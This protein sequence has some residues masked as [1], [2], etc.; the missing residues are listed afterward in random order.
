MDHKEQHHQHHEHERHEKKE[1]HKRHEHAMEQQPRT[2]H[3]I[4]FVVIGLI[5]MAGV[6]A[7]WMW[8]V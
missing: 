4:W 2:I 6:L 7:V 1:E 8:P 5:L 3:P